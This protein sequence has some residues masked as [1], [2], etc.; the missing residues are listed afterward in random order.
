MHYSEKA[1]E[2]NPNGLFSP[3]DS[4]EILIVSKIKNRTGARWLFKCKVQHICTCLTHDMRHNILDWDLERQEEE[5][6]EETKIP[7]SNIKHKLCHYVYLFPHLKY[8][9]FSSD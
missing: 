4:G 7:L 2:Y 3:Q 8:I 6:T 1:G 5:F 9:Y